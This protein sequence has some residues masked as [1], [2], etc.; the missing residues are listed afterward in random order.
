VIFV[1]PTDVHV[2]ALQATVHYSLIQR[3]P[4]VVHYKQQANLLLSMHSYTPL[5]INWNDK[6]KQPTLLSHFFCIIKSLEHL[7]NLK[8][9][10]VLYS[11]LKLTINVIKSQ[12]IS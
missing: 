3:Q 11:G 6:K 9:G 1:T 7:K 12:T 5:V 8:N 4:L 2:G 10:L